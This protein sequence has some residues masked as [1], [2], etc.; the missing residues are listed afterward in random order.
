MQATID[1]PRIG[2]V[3]LG[4]MG[5]AYAGNLRRAGFTVVGYDVA[6][7]QASA[8]ED[9][10]GRA[11][12]SPKAVAAESDLVLV[13]LASVDA[14]R[15]AA[16]GTEGLAEA[17]RPGTIVCEM[18]TLPL[19]AKEEARKVLEAR[20]ATVLDC[21]VSGTGGQAAVRDLVI[22]ASGNEAAVDRARIAFDGFARETRFVGPFGSGIK[23]KYVANLLVTI[24]N[25]A[26]A[27]ALLL[28][29]KSDLDLQLVYDAIRSGAG[30]SRMFEIRGPAMIEG[31]YEPAAMKMDVYLK[32][33]ALILDHARD[34]LCPTPL[35]S[36]SLPF[37]LA[38]LA[39]GRAKQ[40]T[41]ALFAVLKGMTADK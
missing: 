19:N 34:V 15:V 9:L 20:G 26:T 14:L 5:L 8:L 4:I 36:A 16:A 18:G 25:L 31:R 6:G 21:P 39:E 13:A 12:H 40:D 24:H 23:L 41:A 7:A 3:G 32:D 2:I 33:L 37:Y 1:R 30:S 27:E 11:L 22:Y 38:A 17:I 28:A 35:M 29:E 10:G